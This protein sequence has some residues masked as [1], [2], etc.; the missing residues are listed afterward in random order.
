MKGKRI[1]V[2]GATGFIGSNIIRSLVDKNEVTGIDSFEYSDRKSTADIQKSIN[3]I[4]GDVSKWDTFKKVP[5]DIDCIFHFGAPSSI[6]LYNDNLRLCY[7][8]TVNGALNVF[9]FAKESNVGKLVQPSSGSIYAGNKLPHSE[10]VYP[11]P[12]NSY[13]AAKMACEG[14]A[15]F[16]SGSVKSVSLRIF[17]GYGYREEKKGRFA[18]V[19]YLFMKEM[20][21]GK[22]PMVMGNGEQE[23]DFVFIEDVVG[24]AVK[25]AGVDYTGIVNVGTGNPTSF[26]SL[27]KT[28]ADVTGKDVKPQYIPKANAYV[29]RLKADTTLMRKVLGITP[30]G[31]K[32]GVSKFYD[33]LRVMK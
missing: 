19:V 24:A 17:A 5:K 8:E 12:M 27:I 11:V 15:A 18:S 7:N 21:S 33:Y 25:A 14:I 1:L 28:I 16:Y 2:T 3:F 6:I 20:M 22:A 10:S 23:R 9:Q 26:N 30:M 4:E 29:E 32:E 31:L 13:A